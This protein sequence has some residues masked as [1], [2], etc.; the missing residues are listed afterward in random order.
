MGGTD[1]DILNEG[2]VYDRPLRLHRK[3]RMIE[4]REDEERVIGIF[5]VICEGSECSEK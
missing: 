5:M 4:E 3:M 1:H 2:S